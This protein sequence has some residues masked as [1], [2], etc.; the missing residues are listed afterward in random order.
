[1]KNEHD[2]QGESGPSQGPGRAAQDRRHAERDLEQAREALELRTLELREGAERLQL[3]LS[4][5]HLGDWKWEASTDRV[6]LSPRAA[7]IFGLPAH[8][9]IT[10]TEMR[11]ML[12]RDDA[13]RARLAVEKSLAEHSGYSIEYRVTR[14]A[15]D[16][17]WIASK[18]AGTY[19][20]DGTVTGMIG[21]VQDITESRH[22]EEALLETQARLTMAMEAGQMGAWEWIVATGRIK[23]SSTLEAIHGLSP[24]GFGGSFQDFQRDMHPED[25]DR[26]LAAIRASLEHKSGYRIEY[27]IVKPDGA[28][29]WIEARGNVIVDALD[30]PERMTGLCMDITLR[31]QAEETLK[32]ESHMLGLLNR[33]GASLAATLDLQ[34]LVQEVTDAATEL[35]GAKFGAFF[36]NVTDDSGD[37][38]LLYT[39][40][41]A[42]REAFERFGQPRATALFGPTFNGDAPIRLDDVR[43]D[44]RYGQWGPHHGMPPGHLPVCSYL[45]VPVKSRTG[46]V[47]GGLFFGH[48]EPGVFDERAER[49]IVGVASQ[50]GVAIDNA[51]MYEGSLKLAM[52][53]EKLLESERMART[54]A[55]RMSEMKDHFLANLSHELRTPLNAIVGWTQVL[56]HGARDEADLAKGLET[57]ERNA[58]VQTQLIEDLLDMSRITSGKMRLDIQPV[59]PVSVIEAAIESVKPA[60]EAKGIRVEKMLDALAGPVS[61]D[62]NRLQQVMWNLLSN[63]IKFT[64]RGGK[65]QVLL[66]RVNSH[67]EISVADTGIGIEPRFL[68]FVFDRFRQGDAST[69]RKFGGLGLGLSIVKSLVEMHGGTVRVRSPG[70][71]QGTT[72]AVHLPVTVVHRTSDGEERVHPRSSLAASENIAAIDLSGTKVL[73]VD[74]ETDARELIKR[75]LHDCNAVVLTAATAEEALRLVETE[76]PDVFISDIGMPNV[77][78]YELLRRVRALGPARGGRV[79]SIAL[80]AFARSEDRTRALR[81]GFMVHVAKPVEPS[82][83]IATVASIAGRHAQ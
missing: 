56:R 65:V 48:P 24:G 2:N 47:I 57:I 68:P 44:P 34:S 73:V 1:V 10:W 32:A 45:A 36:Y 33:T 22:A 71:D 55:E 13:E 49:L 15:G 17:C 43:K 82:E 26:V 77:D 46:D 18:G 30:N 60:A 53:R 21:I 11:G 5:G 8:A 52:E 75:V 42:P 79:P 4:A 38:F 27:R 39:L 54:E 12:H 14:P 29:A 37:A 25:R 64:P 78:G 76:R 6:H 20:D 63:A 81:A 72:F 51:R 67:I 7:A 31:K 35:S 40:S 3:A 19:A 9:H 80:T 59:E 69:T 74:D 50:A 28:I 23:W 62:P 16:Q 61:G 66:E 41:G 58:R 70:Q 83:L